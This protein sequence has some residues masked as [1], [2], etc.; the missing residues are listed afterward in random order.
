MNRKPSFLFQQSGVIPYRRRE[1]LVEVLLITSSGGQRW[2]IPKG[3]VESNLTPAESA[4][5]EAFEEAG[6]KGR[7]HPE[8]VGTYSYEK[9]GGTC[10]VDVFLMEV[11]NL[12]QDWPE[13]NSRRREWCGVDE[14]VERVSEPELKELL[15]KFPDVVS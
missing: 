9:W 3:V 8:S 1:E 13:K 14:A 6:I 2:V 12:L 7:I 5:K 11:E 10:R 4:A 15:R